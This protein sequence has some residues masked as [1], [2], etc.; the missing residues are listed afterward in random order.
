MMMKDWI[1]WIK[2]VIKFGI[3]FAIG[4]I[5]SELKAKNRF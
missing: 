4:W 3:G 2:F 1:K 5:L